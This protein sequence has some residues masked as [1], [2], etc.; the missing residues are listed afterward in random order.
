[1]KASSKYNYFRNYDPQTGRYTASGPIR[2]LAGQNTYTYVSSDHLRRNDLFGLQALPPDGS[3]SVLNVV[4]IGQVGAGATAANSARFALGEVGAVC[5]VCLVV[6]G[7]LTPTDAGAGSDQVPGK[8]A[9]HGITDGSDPSSA[10]GLTSSNPSRDCNG[11]CK[12]CRPDQLWNTPA[13]ITA[14]LVV[15]ISTA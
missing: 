14:A 15:Y 3:I 10:K 4:T 11:K 13:T 1:M 5:P 7:A 6:I 9:Y 2:L 8:P 12:P